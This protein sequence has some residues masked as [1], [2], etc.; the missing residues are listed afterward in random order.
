M[1]AYPFFPIYPPYF[2]LPFSATPSPTEYAH[3]Y[4]LSVSLSII[5]VGL[6]WL[7]PAYGQT[8]R[9]PVQPFFFI[10]SP[11]S[12]FA[13]G[14]SVDSGHSTTLSTVCSQQLSD[15]THAG[16]SP[17]S[18]CLFLVYFFS[19]FVFHTLWPDL[20]LSHIHTL[21]LSVYLPLLRR[22]ERGTCPVIALPALHPHRA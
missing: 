9:P 10:F 13:S 2:M 16:Y 8:H 12:T 4:P 11:S 18:F 17:S 19:V 5:R 14:W 22:V 20:S 6:S 1:H 15:L 21:S 7:D 3:T